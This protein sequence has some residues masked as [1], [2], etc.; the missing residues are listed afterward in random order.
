MIPPVAR[1]LVYSPRAPLKSLRPNSPK[2]HIKGESTNPAPG[3]LLRKIPSFR[4]FRCRD[5]VKM[6]V[7]LPGGTNRVSNFTIAT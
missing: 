4:M 7:E 6:C 1:R 2:K 5:R 3:F